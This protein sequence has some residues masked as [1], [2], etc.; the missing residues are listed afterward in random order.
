MA[1]KG[2]RRPAT[3]DHVES[4]SEDHMEG[5]SQ[6]IPETITREEFNAF[7]ASLTNTL[8]AQQRMM[9]DLVQRLAP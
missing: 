3:E 9:E 1:R 8:H 5:P 6:Q 2:T 4:I 7:A